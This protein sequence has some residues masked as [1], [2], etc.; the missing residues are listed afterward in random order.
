MIWIEDSTNKTLYCGSGGAIIKQEDKFIY[1]QSERYQFQKEFA[2]A[3][4]AATKYNNLKTAITSSGDV[5][6]SP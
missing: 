6:V 2:D 3:A 5:I 4:T 1:F